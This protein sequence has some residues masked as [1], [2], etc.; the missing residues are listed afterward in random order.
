[1]KKDIVET[2][3]KDMLDQGVIQYINS[4]FS[5]PIVLVGKKDGTWRL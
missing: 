5:S 2:L 1:M 3:V 4:P